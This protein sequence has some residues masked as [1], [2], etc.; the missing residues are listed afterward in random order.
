MD[1]A[2]QL[3]ELTYHLLAGAT[4]AAEARRRLAVIAHWAAEQDARL[5]RRRALRLDHEA[6]VAEALAT[7]RAAT[8]AA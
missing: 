8:P 3:D 5:A 1:M 6:V 7:R 2:E 4:S